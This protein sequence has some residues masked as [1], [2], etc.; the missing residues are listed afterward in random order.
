MIEWDAGEWVGKRD[1]AE[2][3]GRSIAE[4]EAVLGGRRNGENQSG[5]NGYGP[6]TSTTVL[7]G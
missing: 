5:T 7:G 6:S 4:S 3:E 2:R 1:M